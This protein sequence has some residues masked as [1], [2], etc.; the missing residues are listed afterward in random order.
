MFSA[1]DVLSPT[2]TLT[3]PVLLSAL[4]WAAAPQPQLPLLPALQAQLAP[5]QPQP[6]AAAG[7]ALPQP[8]LQ[9]PALQAQL[10]W[11]QPQLRSAPCSALPPPLAA[12]PADW[13]LEVACPVTR[14]AFEAL[15]SMACPAR[16]PP[17]MGSLRALPA[18]WKWW[19][20]MSGALP[21]ALLASWCW[22]WLP[23]V[24]PP[25]AMSALRKLEV[26]P[27]AGGRAVASSA[28]GQ[29]IA[30]GG[31]GGESHK[32]ALPGPSARN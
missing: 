20:D 1:R 17:A 6:A 22:W 21:P 24:G 25:P 11:P 32:R 23:A 4:V 10:A 15:S 26:L 9:S 3:A 30:D 13:K 7:L 28:C 29:S 16:P 31:S 27:A 19:V 14:P 5:P 2:G 18:A 12:L 8:Q